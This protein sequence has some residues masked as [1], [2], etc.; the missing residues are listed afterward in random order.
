[1]WWVGTTK[2]DSRG[3]DRLD[4]ATSQA[5]SFILLVI[6]AWEKVLEPN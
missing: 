1:M 6:L 2:G 5:V 4:T 3:K